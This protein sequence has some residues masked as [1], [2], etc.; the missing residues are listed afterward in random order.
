MSQILDV[1][2]RDTKAGELVPDDDDALAFAYASDYL[3]SKDAQAISASMLLQEESYTDR[4]AQAY[5]AGLL[6]DEGARR[7][8]R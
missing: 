8:Q 6:P 1:Y 7:L 4:V 2:L 5:F 3:A